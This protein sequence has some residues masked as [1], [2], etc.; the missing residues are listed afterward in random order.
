MSTPTH[1]PHTAPARPA[2][3][4]QPRSPA[5]PPAQVPAGRPVEERDADGGERL[6]FLEQYRW[7]IPAMGVACI[8]AVFAAM[9]LLTW[10]AGGV[11]PFNR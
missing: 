11:T 9:I 10:A 2:F 4:P 3:I 5:D 6:G 7:L 8:I 1:A